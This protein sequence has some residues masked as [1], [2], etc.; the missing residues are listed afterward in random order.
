MFIIAET[1]K[2]P[3]YCLVGKWIN[4]LW[5]VQTMIYY[6]AVKRKELLSYEKTWREL[7]C[8][9][10]SKISPFEKTIYYSIP[11]I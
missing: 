11:I 2:K 6:S 8:I 5:Y 1:W 10:L 7:K 9:V 4:E 3:A